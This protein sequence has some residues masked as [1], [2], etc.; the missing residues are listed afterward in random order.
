MQLSRCFCSFYGSTLSN[1]LVYRMHWRLHMRSDT[2]CFGSRLNTRYMRAL[3]DTQL[4]Q[5]QLSSFCNWNK[6]VISWEKKTKQ[7]MVNV[8]FN[9]Y[10]YIATRQSLFLKC[11]EKFKDEAL[12]YSLSHDRKLSKVTTKIFINFIMKWSTSCFVN[13]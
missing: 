10:Y 6:I 7:T 13:V 2:V 5:E 11:L 9:Q 3:T 8:D 1:I 12:Q 4:K